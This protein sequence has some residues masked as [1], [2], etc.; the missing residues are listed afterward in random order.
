MALAMR[1]IDTL[2]GRHLKAPLCTAPINLFTFTCNVMHVR[3]TIATRTCPPDTRGIRVPT[4]TLQMACN[5]ADTQWRRTGYKL[6]IMCPEGEE[7]VRR[8][9]ASLSGVT[10]GALP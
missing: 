1:H 5:F 10:L 6:C 7:P 9:R 3:R 2:D 4:P 8:R